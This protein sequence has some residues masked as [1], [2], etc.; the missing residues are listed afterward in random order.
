MLLERATYRL[1]CCL[2]SP[3][4]LAPWHTTLLAKCSGLYLLAWLTG[5][6]GVVLYAPH[7]LRQENRLNF[8]E[9]E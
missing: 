4:G 9:W 5:E 1:F 2:G 3:K 6:R 8:C 7:L